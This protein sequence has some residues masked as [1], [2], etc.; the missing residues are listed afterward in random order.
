[1]IVM[2]VLYNLLAPSLGAFKVPTGLCMSYLATYNFCVV[3][4]SNA[5]YCSDALA[6]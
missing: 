5:A 2:D 3:A 1:M 6:I 4:F